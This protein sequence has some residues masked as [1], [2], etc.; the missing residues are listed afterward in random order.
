MDIHFLHEIFIWLWNKIYIG[1]NDIFVVIKGDNTFFILYTADNMGQAAEDMGKGIGY[2]NH[3]HTL[4]KIEILY[5]K[6]SSLC[7]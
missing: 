4:E 3:V 1:E 5:V 2:L 7:E 6:L